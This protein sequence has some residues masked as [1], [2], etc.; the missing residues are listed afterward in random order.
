MTAEWWPHSKKDDVLPQYLDVKVS[1]ID[2]PA[3]LFEGLRPKGDIVI[4]A[5]EL[6]RA[7]GE[8]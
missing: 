4:D 5:R 2:G 1:L 7:M 8:S 6:L 3:F